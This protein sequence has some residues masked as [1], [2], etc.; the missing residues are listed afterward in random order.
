MRLSAQQHG[1]NRLKEECNLSIKDIDILLL[2]SAEINSNECVKIKTISSYPNHRK[3][4]TLDQIKDLLI[5]RV[6]FLISKGLF[7]N[8]ILLDG[9]K[10][11]KIMN[12][13]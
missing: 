5:E 7:M 6:I 4:I 13:Y 3:L 9:G 11:V 12:R 8:N 10:S 2:R 1:Y